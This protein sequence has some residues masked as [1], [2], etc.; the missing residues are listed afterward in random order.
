[1]SKRL[2]RRPETQTQIGPDVISVV[3][4]LLSTGGTF[5]QCN[6]LDIKKNECSI[7]SEDGSGSWFKHSDGNT[8]SIL[9]I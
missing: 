2:S 6:M 3:E 5:E 7:A 4:D 9:K 8:V 1:M